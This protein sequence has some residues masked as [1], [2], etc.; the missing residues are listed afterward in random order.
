[1]P[2]KALFQ[3]KNVTVE[4]CAPKLGKSVPFWSRKVNFGAQ[5]T[6]I[7]RHPMSDDPMI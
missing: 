5:V 4:F 6:M 7:Q 3:E 1:M 2:L